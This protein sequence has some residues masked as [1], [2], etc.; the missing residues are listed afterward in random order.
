MSGTPPET[1]EL[2]P[3]KFSHMT[4]MAAN[5]KGEIFVCDKYADVIR[6]IQ[7]DN[8]IVTIAGNGVQGY[9]DGKDTSA[10]F[11]DP[12]GIVV[13]S[14]GNLFI[15]ESSSS[16]IRKIT[17]DGTVSTYAGAAGYGD[18]LG[19]IEEAKFTNLGG[20][21]IDNRDNVYVTDINNKK[22]QED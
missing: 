10:R 12:M 22:D 18:Q 4:A 14:K 21:T 6:K 15:I 11:Q 16:K 2:N 1:S 8:K 19:T 9:K 20:I 17:P 7:N 3:Q 5:S 13:D